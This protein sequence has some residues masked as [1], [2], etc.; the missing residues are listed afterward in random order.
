[1]ELLITANQIPLTQTIIPIIIQQ[2]I[3]LCNV[4]KKEII[5]VINKW[6]NETST[7]GDGMDMY[8][9][10]NYIMLHTIAKAIPLTIGCG[11]KHLFTNYRPG[12]LLSQFSK[13]FEKLFK[14]GLNN[15]IDRHNIKN[16]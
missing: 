2:S 16:G 10:N 12:S 13:M 11:D 6:L 1:M 4:D 14:T 5:E 3:H 8:I 9:G 15:S 7:D